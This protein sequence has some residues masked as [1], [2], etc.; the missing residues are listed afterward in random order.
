MHAWI[1]DRIEFMQLVKAY[2]VMQ[3][4]TSLA[5][6]FLGIASIGTAIR[7]NF[8]VFFPSAITLTISLLT[9]YEYA[10]NLSIGIDQFFVPYSLNF[11][12]KY[13]G[14]MAINTALC[15]ALSCISFLFIQFYS[16]GYA[17]AQVLSCIILSLSGIAIFGFLTGLESAI[18]WSDFTRM[19]I[20]AALCFFF[21]GIAIFISTAIYS[22]KNHKFFFITPASIFLALLLGT[23]G[24][25]Q[26]FNTQEYLNFRAISQETAD[27]IAKGTA[28]LLDQDIKIFKRI[29]N[30]WHL[31][32]SLSLEAK[33]QE[34]MQYFKDINGL[35]DLQVIEFAPLDKQF[36]KMKL[37]LSESGRCFIENSNNGVISIY[38]PI[39]K[40]KEIEQVL[41]AK[42]DI[43][44]TI[45]QA[46][47]TN[48]KNNAQIFIYDNGVLIS[49][50]GKTNEPT[51]E[52]GS[53]SYFK[54]DDL[55]YRFE[56]FPLLSSFQNHKS[57]LS[58]IVLYLGLGI[59]LLGSL[60]AFF[61][62]QFYEKTIEAERAN[63][64]KSNYLATMSHE[65]RTPL[66]GIIATNSL[67]NETNLDDKQ[68]KY[69]SRINFSGKILVNLISNIL[70]F[71]RMEA[72]E[73]KLDQEVFDL[74]H[75]FRD[76]I[77]SLQ[78]LAIDKGIRLVSE[79]PKN[80]DMH[81]LSDPLRL[82][83][84]LNNL[85]GNA[86][87]FTKKGFVSASMKVLK[88]SE[89]ELLIRFEVQDTGIGIQEEKMPKI[90]QSYY[91]I[92]NTV[93]TGL[94]LAISKELVELLNGKID[95]KSEFGKGSTFGFE[96][97]FKRVK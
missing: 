75:L 86:I 32:N 50:L 84:I 42:L 41:V 5:L 64:A 2:P 59:T 6:F 10:A 20:Y 96:I 27:H 28:A 19:G 25:W 54:F 90:F 78:D 36:I 89:K 73:L 16:R 68:L 72:G 63:Q 91:Q 65:I 87:K 58:T 97:P 79:Y 21:I 94:G 66:S 61:A 31:Y 15:L 82:K 48:V 23:L 7:S 24:I 1:T 3:F 44:K 17:I 60:A 40:E 53:S 14:R 35:L 8:L 74:S 69:V 71:S 49:K 13:P 51:M 22:F 33:N 76:T 81:V 62:Q 80:I 39:Y 77:D 70:D 95:F 43:L 30:R 56:V 85:I 37:L 34:L 83:Q 29:A 67:L 11:P 4:N 46:I 57:N 47:D 38:I 45:E 52:I 18:V 26:S 93:G 92:N 9:L 88:E 12:M 55:S